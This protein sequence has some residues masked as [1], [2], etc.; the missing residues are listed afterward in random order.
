MSD[1]HVSVATFEIIKPL[2]AMTWNDLGSR[3]RDLRGVMHRLLNNAVTSCAL[4]GARGDKPHAL[5]G[6]KEQLERERDYAQ[7]R[8]AKG[9]G[10]DHEEMLTRIATLSVPSQITDAIQRKATQVYF[11]YRKHAWRGDKTLPTFKYGAPIFVRD[12]GWELKRDPKGY[13][14]GVRLTS[15]RTGHTLLAVVPCGPTDHA[16]AKRMTDE[17]AIAD[18]SVKLCDLKIQYLERKKKWLV[19]A[20]YSRSKSAPRPVDP[21]RSLAIHGGIRSFLFFACGN[22]DANEIASGGDILAFKAQMDRRRGSM[23]KHLREVGGGARG[24]GKS[25]RYGT[26]DALEDTEARWVKTKCEQLAAAVVKK[27]IHKECGT[28]VLEDYSPKDLADNAGDERTARLIRRWPFAQMRECI[29]RAC[30]KADISVRVVPSSYESCTCPQ[31][32][33][34][35]AAQDGGRGLFACSNEA[36]GLKRPSDAVAAWNMLRRAG[37]ETGLAENTK[38]RKKLVASLEAR[39][40]AE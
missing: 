28:V 1:R 36:C 38:K 23:K 3:L 16:D 15:G 11:D 33:N 6:I 14:L 2:G 19:R 26:Y 5:A 27:A 22:G 20:T 29:A 8:L 12:G 13:V 34:V 40:A 9:K 10:G 37:A 18:E 32:G 17:A 31:C 35:D 39:K 30:E 24:H 4:A 21:T 25:R 7:D